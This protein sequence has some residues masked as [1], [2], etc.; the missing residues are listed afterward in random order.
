MEH[1]QHSNCANKKADQHGYQYNAHFAT[2]AIAVQTQEEQF[3][4]IGQHATRKCPMVKAG[5]I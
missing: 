2:K 3:S 1:Y 4:Q 5:S